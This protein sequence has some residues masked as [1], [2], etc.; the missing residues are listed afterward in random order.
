M[1]GYLRRCQLQTV[2]QKKKK[3]HLISTAINS[4]FENSFEQKTVSP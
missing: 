1:V 2:K 4:S 3:N